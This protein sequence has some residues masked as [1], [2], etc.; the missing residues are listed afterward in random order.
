MKKYILM[1]LIKKKSIYNR[2]ITFSFGYELYHYHDKSMEIKGQP[3]QPVV[4]IPGHGG[5]FSHGR[6]IASMVYTL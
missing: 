1:C 6:F 2:F 5:V 4:F 3:I